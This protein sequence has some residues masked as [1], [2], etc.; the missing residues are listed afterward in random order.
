MS[1]PQHLLK[2]HI[3]VFAEV[4]RIEAELKP[5]AD[6]L[7]IIEDE[8]LYDLRRS[9]LVKYHWHPTCGEVAILEQKNET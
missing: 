3:R 9:Y 4:K 6:M 1:D 5:H 8:I 7:R 2:E